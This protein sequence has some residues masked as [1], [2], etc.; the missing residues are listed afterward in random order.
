MIPEKTLSRS[1]GVVLFALL[2]VVLAHGDEGHDMDMSHASDKPKEVAPEY[3]D[4]YF[5]HPDH[6]GAIYAHI[7]LMVLSWVFVLPVGKIKPMLPT[8]FAPSH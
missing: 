8:G 6:V 1:V 5:A 4:T 2:P 3:P 7:I